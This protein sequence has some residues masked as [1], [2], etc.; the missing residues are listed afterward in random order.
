MASGKTK[1]IQSE[2]QAL[3][4]TKKE[5]LRHQSLILVQLNYVQLVKICQQYPDLTMDSIFLD[6]SHF[7]KNCVLSALFLKD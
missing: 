7:C 3:S 4:V 1:E 2:D 6:E 5:N